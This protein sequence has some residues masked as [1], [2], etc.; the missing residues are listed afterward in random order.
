MLSSLMLA[1]SQYLFYKLANEKGMKKNILSKISLQIAH[2]FGEAY[3]KSQLNNVVKNKQFAQIIRYQELYFEASAWQ[4]LA[5][6]RYTQAKEEGKDM[7]I[8]AGTAKRAFE[9]FLG[10]K[11]VVDMIPP[12]Y[13]ANYKK[14]LQASENHF[15]MAEDKVK[16]VFFEQMPDHTKIPMPD[17]KN[18]VKFDEATSKPLEATPAMNE[19]LRYIIPPQVRKMAGELKTQIQNLID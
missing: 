13:Q 8:A 18:F 4:V 15:K 19:I 9:V 12:D 2:Y 10:C 6:V 16:T 17:K 1:Q 7:G 5:V 14:K 3:Q 11:S